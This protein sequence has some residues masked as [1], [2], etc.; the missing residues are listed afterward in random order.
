M[1]QVTVY[2]VGL[3]AQDGERAAVL[4]EENGERC[5][6][7]KVTTAQANALMRHW[8]RMPP[9]RPQ[10]HEVV[11]ATIGALRAKVLE[12]RVELAADGTLCG[13]VKLGH[14]ATATELAT[15]AGDAIILALRSGA[16]IFVAPEV[17]DRL[18]TRDCPRRGITQ[19]LAP[20]LAN[21]RTPGLKASDC[22][23][24]TIAEECS[25]PVARSGDLPI[26]EQSGRISAT[27]YSGVFRKFIEELSSLDELE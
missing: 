9:F 19:D 16:P 12:S 27:A 24:G 13:R 2:R 22:V 15:D 17:M 18:G 26:G 5:L 10:T 20:G 8:Y 7:L 4:R 3:L 21:D 1:I 6:T 23:P 11:L 25:T 14:K